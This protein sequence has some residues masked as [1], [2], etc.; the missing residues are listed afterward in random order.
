MKYPVRQRLI[1]SPY[2]LGYQQPEDVGRRRH[3]NIHHGYFD[4]HRYDLR[5]RSV[6]R[7]LITNVYPMLVEEHN[8]GRDS[9]HHVYDAPPVP[10]DALMIDVVEEYLALNGVIEC[11]KEKQTRQTYRIQPEEWQ[12]I[13]K[14]YDRRNND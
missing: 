3:V 1:I 11:V 2:E 5:H 8:A 12:H 7:N 14:G 13:K 6:F 9:L 10:P 4:R